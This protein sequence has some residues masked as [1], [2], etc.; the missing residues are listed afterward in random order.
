MAIVK[1]DRLSASEK[2][3][4]CELLAAGFYSWFISNQ[5]VTDDFGRG[6]LAP[7]GLWSKVFEKRID[8][9][10][11]DVTPALIADWFAEWERVGLVRVYMWGGEAW[12]EWVNFQ[13]VPPTK[14][15]YHRAPASPWNAH[16]CA[17]RCSRSAK[18]F[19]QVFKAEPSTT[20]DVFGSRDGSRTVAKS[21][22]ELGSYSVPSVFRSPPSSVPL[23]PLQNGLR[24][25]APAD[26]QTDAVAGLVPDDADLD[27]PDP[28]GPT[29]TRP[30]EKRKA[31]KNPG[32]PWPSGEAVA[33]YESRFGEGSASKPGRI[34]GAIDPLVRAQALTRGLRAAETWSTIVRHA[35]RRY[36][37]ETTH[38]KPNPQDFV[39]TFADWLPRGPGARVNGK[40]R[41]E[42]VSALT[43][44]W[45]PEPGAPEPALETV[46]PEES[47]EVERLQREYR[48]REEQR[49]QRKAAGGGV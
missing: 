20:A 13:G 44:T 9:G 1:G 31:H 12:F 25:T 35:W 46:S 47:A 19:P 8:R 15:R 32:D 42:H 26:R 6:R 45:L 48:E 29:R 34:T 38:P 24:T 21:G 7:A 33:D 36:L 30:V 14:Q 37:R 10:M 28:P 41:G 5:G 27:L 16:T 43:T 23:L 11:T 39:D 2:L 17:H 3:A 49:L 40:H 18:K 4:T 22:T